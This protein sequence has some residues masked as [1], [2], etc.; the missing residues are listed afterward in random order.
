MCVF[1]FNNFLFVLV[2]MFYSF[3]FAKR[4]YGIKV[5]GLVIWKVGFDKF[6]IGET[7][8]FGDFSNLV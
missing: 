4:I 7:G 3:F 8:F 1:I 5:G 6:R 2:Y